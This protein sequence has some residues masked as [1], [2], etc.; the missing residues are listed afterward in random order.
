MLRAFFA[1]LSAAALFAAAPVP[2]QTLRMATTTS[3]A[4]TG[5]LD[6]LL[7]KFRS[8]T[9]ITVQ[10]V[11]VGTGAALKIGEQGDADVVLVHDRESEDRFMAAGFGA[12][13]RDVMY[14]DFIIV[15]F[16]A[17][18]AGIRG[19]RDA[20][21][22]LVRIRSAGASFVSRGDKSGTHLRELQLWRMAGVEPKWEGYYLSIGQ[23][24][25]T[26]LMMTHEKRG[27]TLTD[28]GTYLAYRNKIDLEILL[29]G[30]P[31][32]HNPY[33]II[34]VSP[35]RHPR[36]NHSA[37]LKLVDWITGTEGQKAIAAFNVAGKQLFFPSA[38]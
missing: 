6:Y 21:A 15:G 19:M 5:L 32:L 11:A 10:Y 38:N 24:M 27:Y 7:P 14:N 9:G 25:G 13:R 35:T 36:I 28:R 34:A 1:L 3:T 33:G 12:L 23:G 18:P 37:A 22:A 26:A 2:A 29:Q 30:D 31:R 20:S 4:N 8:R 16:S 17:D